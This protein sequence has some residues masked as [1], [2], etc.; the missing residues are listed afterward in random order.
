MSKNVVVV[1][2]ILILP[3]VRLLL[4]TV[5]VIMDHS[6]GNQLTDDCNKHPAKNV[7]KRANEESSSDDE[8]I[9][10]KKSKSASKYLTS[11]NFVINK[12]AIPEIAD[13]SLND[14]LRQLG[15]TS[16]S[17]TA[18]EKGVIDQ[19]EKAIENTA[20]N[21][22]VSSV[23]D[24]PEEDLPINP[25]I[26]PDEIIN[27]IENEEQQE[28]ETEKEASEESPDA[29]EDECSADDDSKDPDFVVGDTE[30]DTTD[31]PDYSQLNECFDDDSVD[32]FIEAPESCNVP[33]K[34]RNKS[35]VP[36]DYVSKSTVRKEIFDD[37]NAKLYKKRL[38]THRLFLAENKLD[39]DE[40]YNEVI[41]ISDQEDLLIPKRIWDRLFVHQQQC[42]QWLWSLHK[43][44]CGG[45][46]G[47]E[48]GLGKTIQVI[49]FLVALKHTKYREVGHLY[50]TLG[51]VLLVCPATVMH[52]WVQ[53]FQ[54]WWP[55]FRVAILHT[56]STFRG[57]KKKLIRDI[58]QSS[59][60]LITSYNGVCLWSKE[61]SQLSWHYV[62][63]DEGKR[64]VVFFKKIFSNHSF[65][66]LRSQDTQSQQSS[67]SLLQAGN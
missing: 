32:Q 57:D 36:L 34:K 54:S 41:R 7:N 15:V 1:I 49:A 67:G 21:G 24:A 66:F 17:Q 26:K 13:D 19:L 51:P 27:F 35:S 64:L 47:D 12:E 53:E 52:Q 43:D 8:K 20:N 31:G 23:T 16:F 18:Y 59:G 56:S 22:L 48:M 25:A 5:F 50:K 14:E 39:I 2:T 45:I 58:F 9:S 37:G 61:L 29:S 46:I 30:M 38:A 65:Y 55:L 28:A 60:I 33:H 62:V 4:K 44:F 3:V 6:E 11:S 40:D 10:K 42:L 63:L